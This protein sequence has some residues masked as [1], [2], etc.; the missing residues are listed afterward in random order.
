[1][2][3][4]GIPVF[5]SKRLQLNVDVRKYNVS[6]FLLNINDTVFPILWIN[7][8]NKKATFQFKARRSSIQGD[9]VYTLDC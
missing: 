8:V 3:L 9:C 6:S 4:L 2:Q 1:M 7:E 5:A